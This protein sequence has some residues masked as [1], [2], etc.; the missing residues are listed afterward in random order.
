[1]TSTSQAPKFSI[2]SQLDELR[3]AWEHDHPDRAEGGLLA[4]SGFEH[5][6]LL[7]LRKIVYLW[8]ESTETDRQDLRTAQKILAEAVSDITESGIDITFTQVKRTLSDSGLRKALEELWEIFNLAS[9]RTPDLAEHLQFVISGKFEEHE[10]PQQVIQGWRT[11]S[12]GYPKEKLQLFKERVRYELVFDPRADLSTELQT[13]AR[14]ED[15]ETTIARWLGYLLQLGSGFSPESI[16]TFIWKELLHDRSLEAFR[17]T[18]ERLFSLSNKR[19]NEIRYTLGEH[20]TLPRAKLS[21]LQACILEKNVTVLLGPSGSG[22]SALCK[23]GIQHHFKQNFDCLFLQASDITSFTESSDAT[24]NRGIRRLDEL[25]VA[26]ITQK[27]TLVIIDD[28]SD[29]DDRHFDAV[30]NLLQN[31]LTN[32]TSSDVRFILVA[33]VDAKHRINQKISA[34]F[35]NNFVVADVK[36]PQLPIEEILFSNDLPSC[37]I[38]LVHR[39][40]EFGPALNLKLIDWLVRSFQRDRID[41]SLFKNDL[42]LLNWFWCNHVQNGQGF[43]DSGQALMTIAEKLASSFTPDIF[44]LDLS[45]NNEVLRTLVRQD[46]LRIVDGSLA[47]THRFVGDCA[48]FYYLHGK[49]RNIGSQELVAWLRNPLWVQP[50]SWFALQLAMESEASETWQELI[51]EALECEHLQLLDL[52]LDGAILSKQPSSVLQ[53]YPDENLP[54]VIKRLITRL[55]AIATYPSPF[56]VDDSQSTPLRTRIAIQE[57]ITGIPKADLWEPVW[58]WLLS[59]S[60]ENII[61]ESCIVFRAA[62]A[63]LNWTEYAEKFPLRVEVA[64][65]TLDLAQR[66]LLADPDPQGRLISGSEL[67]ELIKLRQQGVLPQPEPIS[68]KC[69]YLGDFESNTF[70]CIVFALRIIP[71]RSTW[72]LRALAGRE[73]VPANK[74]EPTETSP[75]ITRPGVGVLEPADPRGPVGQMNHEFREFMLS[76]N[77]LYLD[78]VVRA[79]R[80]LGSELI[81]ALTISEP[82]YRY[83]IDIDDDFHE[84][85]SN[86][87]GTTG[88]NDIDVC[89]FK[90]LPLLSLLEIN[91]EVAIDIVNTL[92]Q[93]ATRRN[94]ETCKSLEP[95]GNQSE[96]NPEAT[97]LIDALKTDTHE[98]IL[99]IGDV[100]KQFQGERKSLYWHRNYS[101]SPKI[102]N[103]LLMTLEGWLYSR[104]TR[105]QLEH[106]ISIILNRSDTVAMLGVLVTLAKCDFSL[107]SRPLLPLVSSLQLLIW[108]EFERFDHGQDF[109][110]DTTGAWNLQEEHRQEL[111]AFNQL[112]YRQLDLQKIILHLWVNKV[113]PLELQS[114]IVGSWDSHQLTL[115]PEI[116]RSRASKIR[117]RFEHSNWQEERDSEGEQVF[118]FIN[119]IP[120]EPKEAVES[121]AAVWGFHHL[122]ITITCRQILDGEREKTLEIHDRLV[123][124]LTSEK[125]I[126]LFKD[127]LEPQA[128]GNVIWAAIGIVLEP[129]FNVLSQELKTDLNHL[130][131]ALLNFPISL[132]RF[133]RCQLYN[134]DASAFIAHVAPKLLRELQSDSSIRTAAFRCF[135]GIRD[136][137]ACAFMRSWIE[138]YGLEYP[139]TRQLINVAPLIARLISLTR[140]FA[141]IK[142]IQKFAR[143]DGSYM[144]P[145]LE[146]IDCE[147]SKRENSQIEEAW[148]NLQNEFAERKLELAAIVDAFEWIPEVL[149]QPIQQTPDRLQKRFIRASLDW[150]FLTAASIPVLEVK[151]EDDELQKFINSLCEQ[152]IFALL[153]ERED[154]YEEYKASQSKNRSSV[155][156]YLYKSQSQLLYAVI[157]AKHTNISVQVDKL[158]DALRNFN[159]IDCILLGHVIDALSY[160]VADISNTE[161]N[162]GSLRIQIAFGIGDY[163]FEFRSQPDS[164]LRILGKIS[165][166]WEKLIYFLSQ[167]SRMAEDVAR[168]DEFLVQFFNRFKEVLFPHWW[169]RRKLYGVAKS[170]GYKKFRR[171][172]FE[173]LVQHQDILPSSRDDESEALVQVLAELWECDRTWI[174]NKQFRCQGLRTL[175]GQL[176]EIDAVGAR[177]L[178]DRV[179]S[180][181]ANPSS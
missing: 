142:H 9:E 2:L 58:R 160:D 93:V 170:A 103:C 162:S 159:L 73:I 165:D 20:I 164:E 4:L 147:V 38:S 68:R 1:M 29:V 39:H 117:E 128:F 145:L 42:D 154:V 62:E 25:L 83:E 97:Q 78:A 151:V 43:S 87:Y 137:D 21:E 135:I 61:E 52:L 179:A 27:P 178:A 140:A 138:E 92:C 40:R 6:F 54:V 89:T 172:I 33:H 149:I 168:A 158:L 75:F 181:L 18:L 69:Y 91:E 102:I 146:Q 74:L 125:Q 15:T 118:Q 104:P 65:F 98:L 45:I 109:G 12:Q 82:I 36:L 63:W 169:L 28:L 30:L 59:Q 111:L 44:Y 163:L 130:A 120:R 114:I 127:N 17:A 5:Q 143:T 55:L 84:L 80:Q 167:E 13:L 177:N 50:I 148:L 107:L 46:C 79:D 72:F 76:R 34:R 16:S 133:H 90:F 24:A 152:V 110:F 175:L 26:R 122:Q 23:V 7:T 31:T 41:V 156:K 119:T 56:H 49:R 134:L 108:L 101:L 37:I 180:F 3:N 53:G 86:D 126:N 116:S 48:R 106:S 121:E 153:D 150:D 85:V 94:Y 14:D 115:V 71:E 81:L 11:Q 124:F 22:K 123:N 60:P 173:A 35:G 19:L 66:V 64:E 112:S 161:I 8:K 157:R 141:Y 131:E 139:L 32:S 174:V 136:R 155:N 100:N 10:N 96:G 166:V 99:I 171:V 132:D 47:V 70:S 67:A 176:Q 113:I 95:K 57:Q 88:S 105:S 144:I 51:C 77:G 129:P